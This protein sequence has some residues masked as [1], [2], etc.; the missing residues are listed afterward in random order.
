VAYN[1]QTRND[2]IK[3]FREYENVTQKFYSVTLW[4]I[5][6]QELHFHIA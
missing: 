2:R 3:L 1:I 5:K 6:L 4:V